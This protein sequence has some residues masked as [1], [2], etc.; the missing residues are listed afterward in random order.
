[1]SDYNI[2]TSS[3]VEKKKRL[4]IE[5]QLKLILKEN[6]E[7]VSDTQF[8]KEVHEALELSKDKPLYQNRKISRHEIPYKEDFEE[9]M[10]TI[11]GDLYILNEENK[12]HSQFLK[13][14]FN[15]VHSEKKR[16]MQR[17]DALNSL[18]GDMF[19]ITDE[20]NKNTH[21]ITESF[22]DSKAL[23]TDFSVEAISK[24]S[25]QTEEGLLTL[26][27]ISSKN[28][29][30]NGRIAHVSGNGEEGIDHIVRKTT[31]VNSQGVA[32]QSYRFLNEQDKNMNTR[33]ENILD[34]QPDT[35]FEYQMINVPNE[36]K[37]ARRYYDFQWAKGEEEGE[38]LR[39]KLVVELDREEDIN[40]LTLMPYYPNNSS[41]RLL[42]H[43][44]RTS[45]DGFDYLPL[46]KEGIIN[47]YINLTPQT[48]RLTDVF[49]GQTEEDSGFYQ[50]RGVWS[51]P[52]RRARF[53]EFVIDQKESYKE[54]LGQ[55]VYYMNTDNQNYPIQVEEP[56]EL[57]NLP[58]G[59]YIRNVDG[60]RV[61]YLKQIEATTQGWRYAIGLRDINI[62]QFQFNPKSEFISKRYTLPR[63]AQ[64]LSLHAKEIIPKS[65]LDIVNKNNDWIQYEITFD[66]V[67]WHR[68]SPL[69][70]EPLSDNFPPKILEVNRSMIDLTNAFQIHKKFIETD[71][72]KH[73]R[74][75]VAMHRPIGEGFESTTPMLEEVAFKIELE[76]DL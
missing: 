74:F 19:L 66:D 75:R 1:M 25:I 31:T 2:E 67:N 56:E 57:K 28:L 69:H 64:K 58:P 76:G 61:E 35:L 51:F 26:E 14:S 54:T 65:Y 20:E 7:E 24:G 45:V 68:I 23:D 49:T 6:N 41:G 22:N 62:M 43:S 46:Y 50:G 32:E 63:N 42:I 59:K 38:T 47:E 71:D 8:Q 73:F 39:L 21:Y 37:K 34:D 55:A 30:E 16:I 72:A 17:I 44:I 48:Y 60:A 12:L 33:F 5:E 3:Q 52:E 40:W 4:F 29:S 15:S 18:T 9:D 11:R 13:D 53:I 70:H 10:T 27:R 36:F